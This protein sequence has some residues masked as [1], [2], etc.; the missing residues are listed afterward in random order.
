[1]LI[2]K[3]NCF[4]IK[5]LREFNSAHKKCENIFFVPNRQ[6]IKIRKSPLSVTL[7]DF[8]FLYSKKLWQRVFYTLCLFCVL[9]IDYFN[10]FVKNLCDFVI[11]IDKLF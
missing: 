4:K 3:N 7:S 8:V 5:V 1:M 11:W 9:F 6:K 10:F 2:L